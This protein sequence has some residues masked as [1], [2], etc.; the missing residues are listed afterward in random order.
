MSVQD[1]RQVRNAIDAHF[2][3]RGSAKTHSLFM[4]HLPECGDCHRYFDRRM[5]LAEMDPKG[6]GAKERIGRSL[7]FTKKQEP[8]FASLPV[9]LTAS[10]MAAGAFILWPA[11]ASDD[12]FTSRG[13]GGGVV[14]STAPEEVFVYKI[15][16]DNQPL[17][18]GKEMLASDELTF[19]FRNAGDAT[20]LMIY[21][22]D[23]QNQIYWFYPA[24]TNADENPTAVPVERTKGVK[25]LGRAV[26]H[27]YRGKTLRL[28]S[29][30]LEDK[31]PLPS[32]QELEKRLGNA[33]ETPY[34]NVKLIHELN[35]R[36]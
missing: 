6:L 22:V 26:A 9:F 12:G 23:D 32:V 30:F 3:G 29:L 33:Q 36:R 21:G 18:V 34:P 7:G 31:N 15:G 11:P 25:A 5:L 19:S 24:W 35:L 20:H 10:A 17:E 8:K 1:H 28:Y 13:S 14:V 16:A 4:A 27:D 2:Q